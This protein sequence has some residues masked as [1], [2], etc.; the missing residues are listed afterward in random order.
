M[1]VDDDPLRRVSHPFEGLLVGPDTRTPEE[2]AEAE[3]AEHCRR[4][5]TGRAWYL[6][7]RKR[8]AE[9]LFNGSKSGLEK[10]VGAAEITV[11]QTK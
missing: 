4:T 9:T 2:R 11:E 1:L 5:G 7:Y 8:Q 6:A 10:S 3:Y